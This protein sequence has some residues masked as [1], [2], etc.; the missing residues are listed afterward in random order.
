MKLYPIKA[1]GA[2]KTY[3]PLENNTTLMQ[4]FID[5]FRL[6][7]FAKT[8]IMIVMTN[9]SNTTLTN[10]IKIIAGKKM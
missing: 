8:K 6:V 1:K 7:I 3:T 4:F 2:N 9:F 10:K 5:A